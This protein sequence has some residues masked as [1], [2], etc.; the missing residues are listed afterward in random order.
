[1]YGFIIEKKISCSC[2]EHEE[3]EEV[4][5]CWGFFGDMDYCLTEA[6]DIVDYRTREEV[7]E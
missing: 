1:V 5:S 4:D 2:G 3:W 7:N 6:K